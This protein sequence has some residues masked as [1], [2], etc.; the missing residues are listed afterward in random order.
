M[1]ELKVGEEAL[2]DLQVFITRT[3]EAS[4]FQRVR[5]RAQTLG[6]QVTRHEPPH[7]EVLFDEVQRISNE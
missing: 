2:V 5:R 4:G 3:Q 6:L 1:H 7:P